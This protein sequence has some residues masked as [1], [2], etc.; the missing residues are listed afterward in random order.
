MSYRLLYLDIYTTA[1]ILLFKAQ[2]LYS[3]VKYLF[4]RSVALADSFIEGLLLEGDLT[5]LLKVL[6]ANLQKIIINLILQQSFFVI[7]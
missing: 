3:K 1:L 4:N 5:L 6:L 7:L 2:L